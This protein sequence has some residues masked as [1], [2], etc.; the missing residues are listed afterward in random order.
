[1]SRLIKYINEGLGKFIPLSP[2]DQSKLIKKDCKYYLNLTKNTGPFNRAVSEHS[3]P[4]ELIKKKTRTDRQ[5]LGMD[6]E[7]FKEFNNWLGKN[8]HVRRDK[9]A[10]A[11]SAGPILSSFGTVYYF[12]PIGKFNYTWVRA[13]DINTHD[14]RTGWD[15]NEVQMFFDYDDY[16]EEDEIIRRKKFPKY[17]TTNKGIEIAH[18]NKYEI[19]FDCKEYYL[20]NRKNKIFGKNK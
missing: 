13:D 5:S 15:A 11:S 20:V 9:S 18:K 3:Q 2:R 12:F 4:N 14:T 8:G 17:F 10:S 16:E 6:Q 1:M 19:W 7:P